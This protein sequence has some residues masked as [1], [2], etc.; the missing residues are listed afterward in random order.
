MQ[1]LRIPTQLQEKGEPQPNPLEWLLAEGNYP[2]RLLRDHPHQLLAAPLFPLT[3]DPTPS[4]PFPLFWKGATLH[5]LTGKTLLFD[6]PP[7][8]EMG[9]GDL[10]EAVLFTDISPE[11]ELFVNGSK[12]TTFK[13]GDPITIQTPGL[14]IDL[15][16]E[17]LSGTGDFCGHIF[18]S[19][20]PNQI[21][22]DPYEAYDWQI[23]IRTLRRPGPAQIQAHL[24]FSNI[25]L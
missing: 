15:R 1:L 17:L 16:F 24:K 10:F 3:F 8:S 7:I 20:R 23:G 6:L 9:K 22:K 2:S 12:A 18:R 21:G 25:P 13:L 4:P 5:S 14:K 19:N 11:T